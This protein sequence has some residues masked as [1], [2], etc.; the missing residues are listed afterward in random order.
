MEVLEVVS[1]HCDI[2]KLDKICNFRDC[3]SKPGKE[4]LIYEL[5]RINLKTRELLYLY[6]CSKHFDRAMETFMVDLDHMRQ[7]SKILRAK[8]RNMGLV[9][10]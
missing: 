7:N 5:D 4:I 1:Q 3:Q 2:R 8:V 10:Y 9:T 6:L